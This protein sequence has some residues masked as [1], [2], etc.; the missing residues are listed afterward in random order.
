MVRGYDKNQERLEAVAGLGRALARRAKSTCELC[1]E[2]G[3]PLRVCEVPPLPE[4]PDPDRAVMVCEACAEALAGGTITNP[5]S[6]RS[7]Q[8]VVWSEVPA[9]QVTAVRVLRRLADQGAAWAPDLL[10]DVY[11]D[12]EI[13][14]WADAP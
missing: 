6:F 13:Q 14:A 10:D 7:L 5:E 1:E 12:P 2:S 3:L 8:G 11:L 4:D 9:V